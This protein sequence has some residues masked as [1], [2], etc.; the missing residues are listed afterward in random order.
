MT[1]AERCVGRVASRKQDAQEGAPR[2]RDAERTRSAILAAATREFA[3]HGFS[4]AR[5]ERIVDHA[6]SNIRMLYHH[7]GDKKGLY[8]LVLE[9][10]YEDIRTQE[11]ALEFDLDD[12]I[13]CVEK[14]LRFTFNYFQANPLFEGLL[15]NE[16][17]MQGRFVR[18]SSRVPES[19]S[20][21]KQTLAA[22]IAAGEAK[23]VFRPGIDPVQLYITITALS[24]F[25]LANTYSLSALMSTDLKSAAWR[26][27]RLEHCVE[28][29]RS[30]VARQEPAPGPRTSRAAAAPAA[31]RAPRSRSLRVPCP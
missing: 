9:T 3:L 29:V 23:G 7:F 15:R 26:R 1:L 14:L 21:L 6:K 8:A 10:A 18:E 16:N 4:G 13:G 28:I 5:T 17:L 20:Q 24:R 31:A 25:H 12:P 11:A 19:A 22:I 2:R 30:Y 27:A